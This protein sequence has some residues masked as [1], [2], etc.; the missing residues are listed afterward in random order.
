VTVTTDASKAVV[1]AS[2]AVKWFAN[3]PGRDAALALLA[4]DAELVAPDELA[5]EF[6]NAIWAKVR[7]KLLTPDEAREIL[8]SF[9]GAM[10]TRLVDAR[11]VLPTAL[12]IAIQLEH[13]VYDCLYLAL[14]RAERCQVVTADQRL[15]AVVRGTD[16]EPLVVAL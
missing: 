10:P 1:D 13:P 11:D 3:E 12:D 2:V 9:L 8:A 16:Q 5:A 15:Q 14:A 6:G 7:R 4:G